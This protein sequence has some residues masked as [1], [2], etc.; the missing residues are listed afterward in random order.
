MNLS[1]ESVGGIT[2]HALL[3]ICAGS[4]IS[5]FHAWCS[6]LHIRYMF[7]NMSWTESQPSPAEIAVQLLQLANWPS[8]AFWF[9]GVYVGHYYAGLVGFLMG[10]VLVDFISR[11]RIISTRRKIVTWFAGL[12]LLC[13]VIAVCL[14]LL[15]THLQRQAAM[16]HLPSSLIP[17]CVWTLVALAMMWVRTLDA[18]RSRKPVMCHLVAYL[19]CLLHFGCF[20]LIVENFGDIH[21]KSPE[22]VQMLR[23]LEWTE[24]VLLLP[25]SAV[26]GLVV[27]WIYVP[28]FGYVIG[29]AFAR[30]AN[31]EVFRL[32]LWSLAWWFAV[33][34]IIW[35]LISTIWMIREFGPRLGIPGWS[36]LFFLV[37]LP[38]TWL[39]LAY[40]YLW[41][42]IHC[43]KTDQGTDARST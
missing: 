40:V 9:G 17:A 24:G 8:L 41:K 33:A 13:D 5:V 27:M 22:V 36:G 26:G 4:I 12:L 15:T 2:K 28:I 43:Q 7:S 30:L 37:P 38:L 10:C 29:Y 21:R 34:V 32:S 42:R 3:C 1:D 20:L 35:N 25:V 31:K 11:S 6:E 18:G 19:V 39:C 23:R 16:G 14:I